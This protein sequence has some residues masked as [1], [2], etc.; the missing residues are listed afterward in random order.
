MESGFELTE[1]M[2]VELANGRNIQIEVTPTGRS[3]VALDRQ[4][5]ADV[6]ESLEGIVDALA[7]TIHKTLPTKASVKFGVGIGVESGKLT[8]MIVKG[9]GKANLE[10]TLEWD[11]T[12]TI[13]GN[14][15]AD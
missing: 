13:P 11:R 10:I 12:A 5:F 14:Q 6:T 15:A 9:S 3:D 8:A 2:S 4:A 1:P 7:G